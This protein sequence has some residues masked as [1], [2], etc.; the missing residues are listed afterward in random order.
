MGKPKIT[1]NTL[2]HIFFG[3]ILKINRCFFNPFWQ[4]SRLNYIAFHKNDAFYE[5]YLA[6]RRVKGRRFV[7][8]D[9]VMENKNT[10]NMFD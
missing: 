4:K 8:R 7:K 10:A 2:A 6:K 3:K 9:I 5:K 1:V